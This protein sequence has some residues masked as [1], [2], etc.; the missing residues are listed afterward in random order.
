[1]SSNDL[2][3]GT[4]CYGNVYGRHCRCDC[5]LRRESWTA[6]SLCLVVTSQQ[7]L[8]PP[9]WTTRA[10]TSPE[11][12]ALLRQVGYLPAGCPWQ[13]LSCSC[14]SLSSACNQQLENCPPAANRADCRLSSFSQKFPLSLPLNCGGTRSPLQLQRH[15]ISPEL[16]WL[17]VSQ[18]HHC[19]PSNSPR[20]LCRHSPLALSPDRTPSF[21][22]K[23]TRN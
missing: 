9:N 19:L 22:D 3:P 4:A 11:R 21:C 18:L 12:K 15:F 8:G 10:G 17:L 23:A 6:H 20:A 7:P 5:G 16:G 14:P 1:V 13:P 2:I